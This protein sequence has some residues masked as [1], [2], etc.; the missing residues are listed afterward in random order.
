MANKIILKKSSVQGKTPLAQDLDYGELA[1]NYA[2]GKLYYKNTL[3]NIVPLYDSVNT[4]TNIAGG[5]VGGIPY[6]SNTG[7]TQFIPIGSVGQILQSNG[8]TATWVNFSAADQDLNTTSSVTFVNLT[9]NT[10]TNGVIT[11]ADGSIQRT[12]APQ[13]Y[14]NA[15]AA[16]GLTIEDLLPG[17]FYYDDSTESIFI[18]ID[19]GLG[20][21][22]LLDITSR[23][24]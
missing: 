14:T 19:T 16:N 13:M 6:Q 20:Y 8:S 5:S 12:K 17:D 4:A 23:A 15:D 21:N 18:M 11:F 7:T 22:N 10:N 1:L 3:T 9:L 24:A 2:D